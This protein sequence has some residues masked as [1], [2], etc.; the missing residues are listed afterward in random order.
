MTNP[1]KK[2]LIALILSVVIAVSPLILVG[3]VDLITS[4]NYC[5]VIEGVVQS[6]R[7]LGWDISGL[8]TSLLTS[9]WYL[10]ITFP[11]GGILFVGSLIWLARTIY[12]LMP[13]E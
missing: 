8:L 4:L 6:C 13:N 2:P 1:L 3:F 11:V 10:F 12:K 5:Q 9:G 7:V